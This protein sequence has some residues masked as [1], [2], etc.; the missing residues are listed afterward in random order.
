MIAPR[1][2]AVQQYL[3]QRLLLL[4]QLLTRNYTK[5]SELYTSIAYHQCMHQCTTGC[6]S[7]H[8]DGTSLTEGQ[9]GQTDLSVVTLTSCNALTCHKSP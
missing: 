4:Q 7:D 5:S 1:M 3:F 2:S 6:L 8:L 9:T